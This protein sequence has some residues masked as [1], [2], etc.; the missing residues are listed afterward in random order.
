MFDM[1]CRRANSQFLLI[2]CNPS[3]FPRGRANRTPKRAHRWNCT[4]WASLLAVSQVAWTIPTVSIQLLSELDGLTVQISAECSPYSFD[5]NSPY[6]IKKFKTV[7]CRTV[8]ENQRNIGYP[9]PVSGLT[10]KEHETTLK[11]C[12]LGFASIWQRKTRRQRGSVTV[13]SIHTNMH[14]TMLSCM[15]GCCILMRRVVAKVLIF[16]QARLCNLIPI[17]TWIILKDTCEAK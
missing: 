9:P 2:F 4:Q 6:A 8:G 13:P 12:I 17:P 11:Q 10:Q 15:I 5:S 1:Y 7:L 3:C 16:L 14:A